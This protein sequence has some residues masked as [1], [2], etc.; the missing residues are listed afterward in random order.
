MIQI[1]VDHCIAA[2]LPSCNV[3]AA[4]RHARAELPVLI[5]LNHMFF[6][7]LIVGAFR[8]PNYNNALRYENRQPPN[9]RFVVLRKLESQSRL[10]DRLPL[11]S[12]TTPSTIRISAAKDGRTKMPI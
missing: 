6:H 2:A 8:T 1:V 5:R 11:L 4:D 10:L 12:L 9:P 7:N 3:P